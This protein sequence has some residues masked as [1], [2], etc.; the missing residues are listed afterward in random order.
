MLD[1]K[2]YELLK[3]YGVSKT[4]LAKKLGVGDHILS[5]PLSAEMLQTALEILLVEN[6]KQ[7]VDLRHLIGTYNEVVAA[8]G[9]ENGQT[10]EAGD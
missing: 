8:L 1:D 3:K 4:W 6:A 2:L 10:E 9:D 5:Y 7:R